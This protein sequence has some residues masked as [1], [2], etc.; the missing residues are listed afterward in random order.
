LKIRHIYLRG[1]EIKIEN[2]RMMSF[3]LDSWLDNIPLCQAYPMLYELSLD[4]K[5]FVHAVRENGWIIWFKNNLHGVLR[6]QWYGLAEILNNVILS[7]ENDKVLR[8]WSPSS[9]P[10]GNKPGGNMQNM[11]Q[12]NATISNLRLQELK[13]IGNKYS[14]TNKQISPMLER[15]VWFF[16]PQFHGWLIILVQL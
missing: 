3:W 15:L 5:C 10:G 4:Q 11:L 6:A 16:L 13:L 7:E 2:G 14:W 8:K 9:M 1:R 12:F